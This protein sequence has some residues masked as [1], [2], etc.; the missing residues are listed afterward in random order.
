MR[1]ETRQHF[2]GYMDQQARNNGVG[3]AADKFNVAPSVQQKLES[4]LQ[5]SSDFLGKINIIGVAEMKGEKLGLG[6]NGT[7]AG[8]T[9]TSGNKSRQ[10]QDATSLSSGKYECVQ[11]DY[12]THIR[13]ATLDAWAKFKDFQTRISDQVLQRCALDRIM[14]GWNGTHAA[15]DTN[16][17]TNPLLQDVNIGW[18]EHIRTSAPERVLKE[19]AAAGKVTIGPGGDFANLDAL[20]YDATKTMLDPWYQEDPQL[21]AIVGRDLMHDKLFPLVEKNDAPTERLAADIVISQRRLGGLPAVVVP[22]FPAGTVLVTRLD[23]LSIYYQDGARRR[24][25]KDAMERNRIEFYESSNDAFVVEKFGQCA[26]VENI[27]SVTP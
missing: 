3:S 12:D 15:D 5:E 14:I 27:E 25:I 20:V 23:N 18:L 11:T 8:R 21:V 26:L 13:Y 1:N 4:K 9:D 2:T 16:R 22:Y 10:T 24:G 19:G 7:I 17:V 6:V